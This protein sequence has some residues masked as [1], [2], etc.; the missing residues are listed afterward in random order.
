[1]E[2]KNGGSSPQILSPSLSRLLDVIVNLAQTGLVDTSGPVD[3]LVPRV[4][5]ILISLMVM[6]EKVL[7]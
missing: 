1:M 3:L 7:Y 4:L 5:E 2:G 6:A